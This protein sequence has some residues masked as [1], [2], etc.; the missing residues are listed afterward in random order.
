M[1]LDLDEDGWPAHAFADQ[2]IEYMRTSGD[3][4]IRTSSMR[5]E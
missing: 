4:R 2:L 5:A 3:K 1:A